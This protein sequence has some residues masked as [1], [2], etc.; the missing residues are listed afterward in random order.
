MTYTAL[1]CDKSIAVHEFINILL[2]VCSYVVFNILP[3]I[4]DI[5]IAIVY[6]ISAFDIYFGLIVFGTMA[7]YL[8]ECRWEWIGCWA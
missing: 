6:F 1:Y 7:T 3:T 4:A 2:P 8:G 5:I